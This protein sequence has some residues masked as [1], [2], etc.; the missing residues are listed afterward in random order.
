MSKSSPPKVT[1]KKA[2]PAHHKTTAK[3]GANK[4]RTTNPKPTSRLAA[5]RPSN[6]TAETVFETS[7]E[8]AAP[9]H[10]VH[11]KPTDPHWSVIP[12]INE[13]VASAV[14]ST[15]LA[16][17]KGTVTH[18]IEE[19]RA[20]VPASMVALAESNLEQTR[21]LYQRSAS[22]F[23]AVLESWEGSFDAAGQGVVALN[24]KIM[25]IA[26]R[27]ITTGFDFATS[28]TGA[29]TL[30]EVIALQ[31]AYW[32]KQFSELRMQAEETRALL[33]KVSERVTEHIKN[34]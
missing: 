19:L 8:T 23:E 12:K 22:A 3:V 18:Q 10:E 24:R 33:A 29:K 2:R 34:R 31:A 26:D 16:P 13:F 28:L 30:A 9:L 4:A 25:D 20:E 5:E 21:A 32:R 27:N 14:P 17:T 15:M 11:A 6:V 1:A 7:S